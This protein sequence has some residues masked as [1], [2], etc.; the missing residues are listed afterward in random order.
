MENMADTGGLQVALKAYKSSLY[1]E[2]EMNTSLPDLELYSPEQ[3][4]FIRFAQTF[5]AVSSTRR[6]VGSRD[7]HSLEKYRVLASV[8]NFKEF[9]QA[10]ECA[11]ESPM[12]R[13]EEGCD[14]L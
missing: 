5:C 4:F 13:G 9:S 12:N 8:S 3:L 2:A 11:P 7:P 10:F 14:L 1:Y 6:P